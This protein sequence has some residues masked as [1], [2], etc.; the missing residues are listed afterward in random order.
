MTDARGPFADFFGRLWRQKPL[1][2][3]SAIV[4][5]I[6]ILLA[7]FADV[8]A[9]CPFDQLN[10]SDRLQLPAATGQSVPGTAESPASTVSAANRSGPSL[11]L[12]ETTR[13]V[14]RSGASVGSVKR[15]R[16]AGAAG[17]RAAVARHDRH[18]ALHANPASGQ[19]EPQPDSSADGMWPPR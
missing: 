9:P 1:G 17:Q 7:I 4:I 8:L 6:L 14:R 10:L 3:A 15:A 2:I 5:V 11:H 16:S 13:P 18:I 19:Q 12:V